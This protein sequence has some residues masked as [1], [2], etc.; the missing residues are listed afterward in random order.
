MFISISSESDILKQFHLESQSQFESATVPQFSIPAYTPPTE[1]VPRCDGNTQQRK[2]ASYM[3]QHLLVSYH[4]S[5]S[6][7]PERE[8]NPKVTKHQIHHLIHTLVQTTPTHITHHPNPTLGLEIKADS[9][10]YLKASFI[11]FHHK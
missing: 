7:A 3:N 9:I 5:T 8:E 1:N 6:L 10:P 2:Q 11:S 4:A